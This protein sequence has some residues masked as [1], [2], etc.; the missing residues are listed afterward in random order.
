MKKKR[1]NYETIITLDIFQFYC[2]LRVQGK[3]IV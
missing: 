2:S 1:M 3:P